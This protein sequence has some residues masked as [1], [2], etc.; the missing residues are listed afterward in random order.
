M[1][2]TEATIEENPGL[3]IWKSKHWV[4]MLD[5]YPLVEGHTLMLPKRDVKHVTRL[6]KAE[7]EDMGQAIAEVTS[8]LNR[9]YGPGTAVYLKCG[10][11]SARTISHIHIHIIPRKMGDRLW[12]GDKSRIV[13][14][15]TSGFKR[16]EP[17]S[18]EL[19][20]IADKIR[21]AGK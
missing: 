16:M 6:N 13:L 15:R 12:D 4:A 1:N 8:M 11:G 5:K 20:M 9:T 2:P 7:L 14:D 21:E 17:D 10:E 19:K 18:E 3:I